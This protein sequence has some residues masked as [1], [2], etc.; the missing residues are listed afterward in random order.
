MVVVADEAAGE[1]SGG[2]ATTSGRRRS[3]SWA[4]HGGVSDSHHCVGVGAQ[5]MRDGALLQKLCGKYKYTF[6]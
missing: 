1:A 3:W 6:E 4:A 2:T 5:P